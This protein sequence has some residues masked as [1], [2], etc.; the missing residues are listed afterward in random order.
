MMGRREAALGWT[1]SPYSS[2]RCLSALDCALR[3]VPAGARST[4]NASVAICPHLHSQRLGVLGV[5]RMVR[6]LR[7]LL[8][9]GSA[10]ADERRHDL[11]LQERVAAGK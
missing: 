4:A 1:L 8:V 3:V 11:L 10:A 7:V 6:V 9:Q 2:A 5:L